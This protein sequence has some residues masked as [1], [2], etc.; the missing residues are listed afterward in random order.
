M[1]SAI[2]SGLNAGV[3]AGQHD[4]G[5]RPCVPALQRDAG[6]VQRGEHVR[7]ASSVANEMPSTVEG[8]DRAVR[9]DR[10][11]RDAALLHQRLE[12]RPDRVGALGQHVGLLVEHLIEDL[13]ALVGQA[14]LV[15][16]RVHQR[17]PDGRWSPSP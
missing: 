2:G 6:Q 13:D 8:L 10:E 7:V 14:H 12:V 15:R 5:A 1:K 11:L 16:V 4:G 9:V 17:P 3:P